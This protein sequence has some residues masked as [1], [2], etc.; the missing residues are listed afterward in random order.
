MGQ[1][2]RNLKKLNRINYVERFIFWLHDTISPKQFLIFASILV[3]LSAGLASVILKRFVHFIRE[4]VIEEHLLKLDFKYI[5]LFMPLI[6]I[7]ITVFLVKYFFKGKLNKGTIN[8]LFS[9]VKKGSFIPFNQMYSHIITSGITIG[10]G[11]SAGLESPIASTGSAIGSN[12]AQRYKLSYKDRTLLLAAGA[13]GGIAGA[14]NAPIAGVL[15]ALE[16]LLIDINIA[17]FIPLLIASAS[18]TLI[19]KIMLKEN[20]LLSFNLRQPFDYYN[21]PHYIVLGF[22]AG[23]VSIYHVNF[24]NAV[25][26][27]FEKMKS[28]YTKWIVGGLILAFLMLIFPSLFGEGY[29]SIKNLA[30]MNPELLFKDSILKGL[31]N[32]KL[33]LV[34]VSLILLLKALAVGVTLGSGGNGGNFAPSLFVGACLG[35]T[36]AGVLKLVGLDSI[37]IG[38][39]TLVAM[40]GILSGVF[41]APLTGIFLIAEIT[42]GYELIIPLMIV[43]SISFVF[44]KYFHPET[45]DI[46]RL[47]VRGAIISEDRDTTILGKIDVRS[48]VEN[49]F[50]HIGLNDNLRALVEIVKY[51][52]RNTYP[53]IDKNGYLS[54]LIFLDDIREEMFDEKL[55]DKIQARELMHK[56]FTKIIDTDDIF[57]VMKKFEESGQWNLP[58]VDSNNKHL[59]FISKSNI[60]AK[61]RNELVLNR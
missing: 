56:R 35:F 8:I 4:V 60:L 29:D 34:S 45:T 13:A 57:A 12:F 7:G 54:G 3:G 10:F 5:Y 53:V 36:F 58:V 38:N 19:S 32:P 44:V 42:G 48:L 55:Y 18:G 47:K 28:I 25:E 46:R 30:E 1:M 37:P 27:R 17:A 33:I 40:A 51:S 14:F 50:K 9:V 26:E 43:S 20:I 22:L 23:A 41:H 2:N 31:M 16:V 6:G 21:L 49:N 11:G 59:G 24:F 52:T 39:F 61:Y 15:F